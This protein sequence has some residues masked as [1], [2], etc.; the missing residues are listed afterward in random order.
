MDY[1]KSLAECGKAMQEWLELSMQISFR[2]HSMYLKELGFSH[3]Q[4]ST[5]HMLYHKEKCAVHDV[6]R[7]QG[8]SNPAASQ[9]LD[10]LVKRNLVERFESSEDRRIKY[11]KLTSEG[12]KMIKES[13]V[14]RSSWYSTLLEDLS[15]DELDKVKES[16]DILNKRIQI[17]KPESM[18]CEKGADDK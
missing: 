11:H 8:I 10:Q 6:S 15:G 3:S 12:I 17:F 7:K 14:A 9:L 2:S 16:L 13:F 18:H 1:E 4:V 5:L